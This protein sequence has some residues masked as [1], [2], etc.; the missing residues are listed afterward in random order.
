MLLREYT[1]YV[2]G[3]YSGPLVC[4]E[5]VTTPPAPGECCLK[6][7]LVSPGGEI[8]NSGNKAIL[9]TYTYQGPD[10]VTGRPIYRQ[11]KT[12]GKYMYYMERFG[13]R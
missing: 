9:G 8:N 12:N 3:A 6:I 2:I 7:S 5:E 13:V 11:D 1:N 4:D 10:S